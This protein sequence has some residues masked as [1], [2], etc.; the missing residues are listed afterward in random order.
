MRFLPAGLLGIG[1][2]ISQ[3]SVAGTPPSSP[4]QLGAVQAAVDFCT[5]VDSKDVKQIKREAISLLPDMTE[6]RVNAARHDPE[7]QKA[8][9]TIDSVLKGLAA[10][11]AVRLC[12]AAAR[13]VKGVD[14]EPNGLKRR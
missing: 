10:S 11:D 14:R 1:M 6:A 4:Q 8:Y 3:L 7:F 13:E 9:Q 2:L 12:V 5:K